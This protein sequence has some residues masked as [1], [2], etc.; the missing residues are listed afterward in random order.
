MSTVT[1]SNTAQT[2]AGLNGSVGST[3]ALAYGGG[4][5]LTVGSGS[6]AGSITDPNQGG[7]NLVKTTTGTLY[8]TGANTYYGLTTVTAAHCFTAP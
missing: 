5:T 6:F 8:L 7:A 3:L 2:L 1:F 4:A